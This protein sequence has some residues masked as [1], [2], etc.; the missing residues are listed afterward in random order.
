MTQANE[1][2]LVSISAATLIGLLY[3]GLRWARPR[4]ASVRHDVRAGRDALVG[5]EPIVDSITGKEIAPALPGIGQ[6]MATVETALIALVDNERRLTHLETT[7]EGH[8]EALKELRESTVERIVTRAEST[9]AFR[10]M[11]AA[12]N[13]D[14]EENA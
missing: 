4:W 3:A 1:L 10:A 5:R 9:A 11:E 13:A 6:R 14:P 7:V 8:T 12:I 2:I